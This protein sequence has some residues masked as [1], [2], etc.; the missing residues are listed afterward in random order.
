MLSTLLAGCAACVLV[1]SVAVVWAGDRFSD[2]VVVIRQQPGALWITLPQR[3][4]IVRALR[5]SRIDPPRWVFEKRVTLASSPEH[6]PVRV[7]ALREVELRVNGETVLPDRGPKHWKRA[8]EVDLARW[9][10]AGENQIEAEVVN[11]QGPPLLQIRSDTAAGLATTRSGW[12]A[13]RMGSD[14][15]L[16]AVLAEDVRLL[17]GRERLPEPMGALRQR[18]LPLALLF[19]VCGLPVALGARWPASLG[20]RN[21]PRVAFAGVAV[22]WL[23][24]YATHAP[25]MPAR[26]GFDASAHLAYVNVLSDEGRLPDPDESWEAF[27]PPLYYAAAAALRTLA[28]SESGSPLDRALMRLLPMLAGLAAAGL[29]GMAARRVAPGAPRVAAVATLAAG[30]LPMHVLLSTFISNESVHTFFVS[31]ALVVTCDLLVAPRAGARGMVALPALLGLALLTKSPSSAPLALLLPAA[32]AAKLWLVEAR[33]ARLAL[34]VV[35]AM[36]AGV[37]LVAAWFYVRNALRFG[38]P[39]ANNLTGF[40]DWTYWIPPG[41]HTPAWYRGFGEVFVQPF[42]SSFHSYADGFYSSFW[43]DGYASGRA[44]VQYPNKWWDYDAMAAVYPLALPATA[45]LLFGFARGAC[46]AVRDGDAGRR[47]ALATLWL[48]AFGMALMLLLAT[49]RAPFNCMPKAFYTLPSL[50]SLA[51]AFALGV[52]GL[53]R[54]GTGRGQRLMRGVLSGYGAAL[55]ATIVASFLG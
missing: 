9:L 5:I 26:L 6:A 2:R 4:D 3:P 7:R 12:T 1:G 18:A 30:L 32:V 24:L 29:A 40:A 43:G 14:R 50:V 17:P 8:R 51:L 20:G 11:G 16:D 54:L 19:L 42:F 39:F 34:G 13:Q 52:D 28:G 47:L 41:F 33:S 44:S 23:A 53:A 55:T 49:L 21:L 36:L 10:H 27:H 22:F 15:R 48:V 25:E 37:L 46:Q 45:I 35:A 38:D 31:A